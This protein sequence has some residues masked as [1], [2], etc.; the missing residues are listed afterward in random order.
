M[1]NFFLNILLITCSLVFITLVTEISA[2]IY[3][4]NVAKKGKLF[5]VNK[6]SGWSVIPNLDIQRKNS[7]GALWRIKTNIDG[8]R[9]LSSW[10]SNQKKC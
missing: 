9:G 1:K 7:N 10:E 3:V 8:Y 5:E 2:Q 4:Y 6:A